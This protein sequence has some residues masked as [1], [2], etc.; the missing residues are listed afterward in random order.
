M[1]VPE[2]KNLIILRAMLFLFVLLATTRPAVATM[3]VTN[4]MI[5]DFNDYILLET[6]KNNSGWLA[7]F[8]SPDNSVYSGRVDDTI[9]K[10]PNNVTILYIDELQVVVGQVFRINGT[11]WKERFF[12]WPIRHSEYREKCWQK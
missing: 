6:K 9:G 5:Y 12:S 7:C 10:L 2:M 8:Y 11:Q 3:G 4:L 1:R